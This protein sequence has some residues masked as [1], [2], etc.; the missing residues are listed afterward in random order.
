MCSFGIQDLKL[1]QLIYKF[2]ILLCM[3]ILIIDTS[4]DHALIGL[5]N[6]GGILSS[7]NILHANQLSKILLPSI[8][9][10]LP[11]SVDAVAVGVGPGSYT[12]T[13][14]GVAAALAIAFGK[15]IPCIPFCSLLAFLPKEEGP[16]SCHLAG[17][18]ETTYLLTGNKAAHNLTYT[19][20]FVPHA[21]APQTPSPQEPNWEA[22]NII[23]QEKLQQ[24]AFGSPQLIYF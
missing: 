1:Y 23:L 18:G 4:T 19:H 20:R 17:K 24:K 21:E 22:L 12:G 3:T 11:A 13:R 7:Q 15:K 6:S 14:V 5:G 2:A 8:E 9:K 10:I 16:F